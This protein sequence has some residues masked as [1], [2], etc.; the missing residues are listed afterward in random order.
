[1]KS[2][3]IWALGIAAL[4]F[5]SLN[6]P[7]L[8]Q[9]DADKDALAKNAELF[10]EAFH[11]GSATALA[12]LWTA[13][14]DITDPSGRNLKG[15]EAIEK[16]FKALF[17]QKKGL[18]LGIQSES[19]RFVSPEVAI[20]DG[21]TQSFSADGAPLNKFR[22]TIVHAKKD[23]QWRM[24]SVR[25]APFD[26]PSNFEHLRP[27]EG[28]IGKWSGESPK[29]DVEKITFAWGENQNFVIG[30]YSSANKGN[31]LGSAKQ[32]IG[33]DPV[34]KSI[35]SWTF[36]ATGGFS[37]GVWAKSGDHW[38]IKTT[39]VFQDGKKASAT[40][41]VRPM[42]ANTIGVNVTNRVIDGTAI[43]D[44]KEITLKRTK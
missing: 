34:N 8:A 19:L 5:F 13:D 25:Q 20:E 29:G 41:V 15:R 18:K 38:T 16:S 30:T 9:T 10:V 4:A 24:C 6:R 35:R 14:G 36:D 11:K 17:S 32:T 42:D 7:A 12:A 2:R 37:E 43:P 33:W 23:G 1:M 28:I 21:T 3:L 31:V 26:P 44:S 40:F 39:S 27:L 22:Y